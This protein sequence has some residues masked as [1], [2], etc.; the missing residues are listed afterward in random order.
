MFFINA[1]FQVVKL[2]WNKSL[3]ENNN[4]E[5]Q[6]SFQEWYTNLDKYDLSIMV[7]YFIKKS[8]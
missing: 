8:T 3:K 1:F 4:W 2:I 7:E 6:E 5:T